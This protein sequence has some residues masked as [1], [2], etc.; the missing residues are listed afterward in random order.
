LEGIVQVTEVT[1]TRSTNSWDIYGVTC[2]SSGVATT[3]PFRVN[4]FT[5][6]DQFAPKVAAS[7][8][9][10]LAVWSSLGQDGSREGVFG[11][12]ITGAGKPAGVEFQVNQT[13][14]SRQIQPAVAAGGAGNFLVTWSSFG[15]G[16][17]FDLFGR[18]Y[19]ETVGQ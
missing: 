19:Q 1:N 9:N 8:G 17:S 5:Y 12:L 4:T 18:T 11:Q 7:G 2:D 15:A 16:T 14:I 13:T 10:Y 6:G 3:Q